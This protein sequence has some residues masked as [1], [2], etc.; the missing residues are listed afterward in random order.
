MA[1]TASKVRGLL[2]AEARR[3]P[4]EIGIEPS[5][6]PVQKELAAALGISTSHVSKI[7][8]GR[9][10]KKESVQNPRRT[11]WKPDA[12]LLSKIQSWL[13]LRGEQDVWEAINSA[14]PL[15]A[16]PAREVTVSQR[17][18]RKKKGSNVV[19]HPA[20]KRRASR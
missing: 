15:P 14:V 12:Y 1:D 5:G 13:N 18:P 10:S 20:L 2:V 11:E 17:S 3:R 16:F 8:T 19:P 4:S 6:R 7:M 9:F